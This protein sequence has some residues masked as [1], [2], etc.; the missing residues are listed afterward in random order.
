MVTLAI[1]HQLVMANDSTD[2][3]TVF[4]V[5]L[6]NQFKE[7]STAALAKFREYHDLCVKSGFISEK[8]VQEMN[9]CATGYRMMA[10]S[11]VKIA[12]TVSIQWIDSILL[13]YKNISGLNRDKIVEH[14]KTL[15]GQG[16]QLG[17][18]FKVIAAWSRDLAGNLH[19]VSVS[20]YDEAES[21]LEG[22]KRELEYDQQR[23]REARENIKSVVEE[24]KAAVERAE[25]WSIASIFGIPSHVIPSSAP[26]KEAKERL[27]R[28]VQKF[29][30]TETKE[31][32]AEVCLTVKHAFY[33]L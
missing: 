7:L 8:T 26:I 25:E 18:V 3:K 9:M 6:L 21:C 5:E 20:T 28:E 1:E 12:K 27:A 22:F 4:G 17:L 30:A 15:G 24:Y 13:F 16:K 2:K 14:L 29:E 31:Q 11:T 33:P 19:K 10:L 32:K 23:I